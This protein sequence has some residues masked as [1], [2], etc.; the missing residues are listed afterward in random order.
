MSNDDF[1]RQLLEAFAIEADEHVKAITSGILDLEKTP[2]AGRQKEVLETTFRAAHSLKGAAR[3]VNR[4]D[5]ETVCQAIEGV[6]ALWKRQPVAVSPE[7]FDV[8]NHAIDLVAAQLRLPAPL[9]TPQGKQEV[10]DLVAKLR[11]IE[12][13]ASRRR[14]VPAV[15]PPPTPPPAAEPPPAAPVE[16]KPPPVAEAAPPAESKPPPAGDEASSGESKPPLAGS[17]PASLPESAPPPPAESE[18]AHPADGAEPARMQ[19][20]DTIRVPVAKM[21][22]LL[23]KAE[24]MI[25]V[26]LAAR[27]HASE[28]REVAGMLDTWRVE[29]AKAEN[30][31]TGR[32]RTEQPADPRLAGLLEWTRSY[33]E[34]FESRLN[35]LSK[36]LQQDE[37]I[38]GSMVDDLLEETKRLVMLPFGT[39][40]DLFPKQVRDLARETGKEIELSIGGREVE[41]DKRILEE[42]KDPLIHLVRNS[43][44]HGIEVPEKRVSAGKPA[45]GSLTIAVSRLEGNKV[46]IEVTDDGGGIDVMQVKAAAVRQGVISREEAAQLTRDEAL[47]LIFQSGISTSAIITELSGRGLGMAIVREKVEKLGGQIAIDSRSGEGTSFRILLPVTLA[48]FKGIVVSANGQTFVIPNSG[49]ELIARVARAEISTVENRPTIRIGGRIL[50]L[51]VLADV[52]ELPAKPSTDNNGY[53]EIVIVAAA[54]TRIAFAVDEVVTEQEVLVKP[55]SRPLV[56]VRNISSAA[57]LGSGTPALILNVSDLLKSA[58][59]APKSS[60]FGGEGGAAVAPREHRLL[61]ADD[62]VTSRMLL[63]NI[64]EAAGYHVTTAVDGVEAFTTLQTGDFDLLVSDGE[65][66]RMGGFELTAKVRADKKFSELPVIIV[67]AL[68]SREDRERGIDAGANA[69]IVKSAFD[70]SNLIEII[71]KLIA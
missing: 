39:L 36:E 29:W 4:T 57:V 11:L 65:M 70:Q 53:V 28:L 64:L 40:L 43:I 37:R 27:R 23:R 61:V 68:G 8:L 24:G 22:S 26:K 69:Y 42:M 45:R 52:L 3:A 19:V 49:V 30:S 13:P 20:A 9:E 21:S 46:A 14:A 35:G 33:L 60:R 2:E 38:V 62:S 41:I 66:P 44:D 54:Q 10:R 16:I 56:R 50:S 51:A 31:V 5:I 7:T 25:A 17:K 58:V 18:P 1:S 12:S 32:A 63:K 48:T 59:K 15:S 47:A 67:T 71:R 34:S 6:F 55:L